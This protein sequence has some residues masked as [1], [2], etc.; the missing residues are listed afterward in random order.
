MRDA[1]FREIAATEGLMKG[2][3][4]THTTNKEYRAGYDRIEWGKGM[5]PRPADAPPKY[6]GGVRCDMDRGPCACGARHG[7]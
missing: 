1:A 2:D 7:V 6:N 5:V 4:T 3:A